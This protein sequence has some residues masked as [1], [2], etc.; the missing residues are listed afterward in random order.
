MS[1]W[2]P[3]ETAPKD[4]SLIIACNRDAYLKSLLPAQEVPLW[5]QPICIGRYRK[6]SDSDEISFHVGVVPCD[7]A[8]HW[9]SLPEAPK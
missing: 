9:M 3:I 7:G 2:K 5:F 1:E 8:T 4:G 6:K